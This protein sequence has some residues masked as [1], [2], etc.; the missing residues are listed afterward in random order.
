MRICD[1]VSDRMV[2]MP[3]ETLYPD[4]QA[5]PTRPCEHCGAYFTAPWPI[6]RGPRGITRIVCGRCQAGAGD[7]PGA[8]G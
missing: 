5:L 2:W 8:Q 1:M 4:Q 3:I 6:A 7:A